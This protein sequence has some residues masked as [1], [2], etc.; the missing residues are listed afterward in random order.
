MYQAAD[1]PSL[2]ASAIA[3]FPWPGW[4]GWLYAAGVPAAGWLALVRHRPRFL[5]A[6][7]AS[8]ALEWLVWIAL[9][10]GLAWLAHRARQA[11]RLV[12]SSVD[13]LD[14]SEDAGLPASL[15][16]R[17]EIAPVPSPTWQ[18]YGRGMLDPL[19][20]DPAATGSHG[21]D[22]QGCIDRLQGLRGSW[23]AAQAAR[24]VRARRLLWLDM[25]LQLFDRGVVRT[26]HDGT[27]P[28]VAALRTERLLLEADQGPGVLAEVPALFVRRIGFA[29]EA[30]PEAQR[31]DAQAQWQLFC[32]LQALVAQ[33]RRLEAHS[34]VLLALAWNDQTDLD[35]VEVGYALAD[36]YRVEMAQW[37]R[38]AAGVR[39][40][41]GTTRLDAFL[42]ARCEGPA[43]EQDGDAIAG[44]EALRPL[45]AGMASLLHDT[46]AMLVVLADAVERT[47]PL[48][49]PQAS[50]GSAA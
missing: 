40:A 5:P 14:E 35:Q 50:Q 22:W 26:L 7:P 4:R 3:G 15:E 43:R 25:V 36:E 33:E 1:R 24:E 46:L 45:H 19:R 13:R 37:L 49:L 16:P 20:I 39:L 38:R 10:I 9:G 34:Q 31:A 12:P 11:W 28:D 29:L 6:T 30:M 23:L 41:G 2:A 48:T 42:L 47:R 32:D 21:P 18:R 27:L 44:V 8:L 17:A